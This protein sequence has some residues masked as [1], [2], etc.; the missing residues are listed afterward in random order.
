MLAMYSRDLRCNK[1]AL[2]V[3]TR[4]LHRSGSRS[5]SIF[6]HFG[7]HPLRVEFV[8]INPAGHEPARNLILV[9]RAGEALLAEPSSVAAAQRISPRRK[10]A[11]SIPKASQMFLNEKIH[12]LSS[13]AANHCQA[14]SN[15]FRCRAVAGRAFTV[16][17]E[18]ASS[19]TAAS[20][21]SSGCL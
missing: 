20:N 14:S 6:D 5:L 13:S 7:P 12:S 4:R 3:M 8:T 15:C 17:Q 16:R 18:I 1:V 21:R 9:G 11:G 10:Y 19:N 2:V